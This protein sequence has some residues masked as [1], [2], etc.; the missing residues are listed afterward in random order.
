M[1]GVIRVLPATATP[2]SVGTAEARGQTQ[3]AHVLADI[4]SIQ[5]KNPTEKL[6][7]WVGTGKLDGAE[8]TSVFP[9]QLTVNT[10]DTVKFVSH[11]PVDIHTVTFGPN[12]Y[13]GQIEK[14]FTS[15]KLVVNP[16]GA[17]PSEPPGPPAPVAYDGSNHG[18]GYLSGGVL[19]P[20]STH[21]TPHLFR[22]TFTK[23]GTYH[24]ECVIHQHMDGTIVV[25]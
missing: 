23:P 9:K 25:R 12:A 8:V 3:L 5:S 1:Q 10:G 11:D 21:Q 19:Y 14:T 4:K 7:V 6:A 17:F 20:Y 16:F 22:V 18:N 13:T 24:Y 15:P 2:P